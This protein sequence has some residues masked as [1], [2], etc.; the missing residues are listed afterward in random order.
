LRR[1]DGDDFEAIRAI[2]DDEFV[3][4][5]G[6][7]SEAT[8]LD[9]IAKAWIHQ[10]RKKPYRESWVICDR[11][12]GDVIGMRTVMSDAADSRICATGASIGAGWRGRGLGSEELATFV[13]LMKHLDFQQIIASARVDNYRAIAL[14][15]KIGF[16]RMPPDPVPATD[17]ST[18][19]SLRLPSQ[20]RRCK[21]R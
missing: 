15:T 16:E 14:Y 10:V 21:L 13:A 19:L 17:K 3:H 11:S 4:W 12:S 2:M 9:D 8:A 20:E 5:N 18:W 7:P 1:P 6:Y